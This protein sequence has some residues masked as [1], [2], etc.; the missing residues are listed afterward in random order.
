M[1]HN[2]LY[3]ALI[4]A[5]FLLFLTAARPALAA[6]CFPLRTNPG[7]E[8]VTGQRSA[9]H[10]DLAQPSQ[11]DEAFTV[12]EPR[13]DSILEGVTYGWIEDY[14]R[15]YDAPG[16]DR[17][18]QPET[19]FFYGPVEDSAVVEG[20]TWYKVWGDW[21]PERYYH[22][23]ETS[24]FAGVEVNA[25]PE[26]PFGW[27][28]RPV[29]PRAE[30]AGEVVADELQRYDFV[31]IYDSA[32]D[33]GGALWYDVGGPDDPGQWVRYDMMALIQQRTPPDEVGAEE[34][35]VDV[36]LQ[37]QIFA[38]YEGDRMVYAGLISSGLPRWATRT[39]LNQVWR[40]DLTTPM[41]GGERGD[42]YY[43]IEAVPHTLY[44]DGEIA[45][46]G[47]F[48]H[49]DFGRMKSHGCVNMAP[50]V[51][52]WVYYWSEDAPND[53]WVWVHHSTWGEFLQ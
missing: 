3:I 36:D 41:E 29:T 34:Y 18:W 51:A 12:P 14:A 40:R 13:E 1:K 4:V 50:R 43:Y 37:Q 8:Q 35:W 24:T 38:A 45:L 7:C 15:F 2:Q 49:D 48:W 6:I 11:Q 53:L 21:L 26:R 5:G 10:S 22:I 52:E 19:G 47:A 28:L 16:G 44:F 20:D 46:H 9:L 32:R 39:G 31:Q 23:V 25:P 27:I 30:P 17:K 42:D 33:G